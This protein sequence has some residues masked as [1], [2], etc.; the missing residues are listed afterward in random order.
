M[1]FGLSW[2][3]G[4]DGREAQTK[5][6]TKALPSARLAAEDGSMVDVT[7]RS[8]GRMRVF[9]P[10]KFPAERPVLQLMQP[11]PHPWVDRYDQIASA[12][13][14]ENW[15]QRSRL[16]D[17]VTECVNSLDE[18]ASLAAN[19]EATV[20]AACRASLAAADDDFAAAEAAA[21]PEI[22]IPD[23]FPEILDGLS[24][25]EVQ[26]LI[27][28]PD[29]LSAAV[30]ALPVLRDSI[31][32]VDE[33]RASNADLARDGVLKAAA[34]AADV[35]E[36]DALR[37]ELAAKLA[38]YDVLAAEAGLNLGADALEAARAGHLSRAAAADADAVAASEAWSAGALDLRAFVDS[39]VDARTK[40]HAET[41]LSRQVPSAPPAPP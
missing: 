37:S 33:L 6:L 36:C 22:R 25:A 12:P 2:G 30:E 18:H 21:P 24:E 38:A 39:F 1:V 15:T 8:G 26:H 17:V 14:L 27:D 29:A 13:S 5:E 32:L 35:A 4:N 16:L 28:D 41:A 23:A 10:P 3:G 11:T 40:F 19:E 20:A 31:R 7:L 9:L 34:L